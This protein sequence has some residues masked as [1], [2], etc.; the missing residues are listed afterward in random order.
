MSGSGAENIGLWQLLAAYVFILIVLAIV[1]FKK[2]PREKLIVI[3]TVRMTLQLIL[4]SYVLVYIFG[5]PHP[6]LTLGI[7]FFMLAFAVFNVY[8]RTKETIHLPLKKMIALAMF[9][10]LSL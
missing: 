5:H 8:Q 4:A 7:I 1:R 9:V 10:G 6:L 3:A 2:I